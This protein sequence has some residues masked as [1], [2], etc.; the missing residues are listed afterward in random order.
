MTKQGME[1]RKRWGRVPILAVAAVAVGATLGLSSPPALAGRVS[2]KPSVRAPRE[3][4]RL[5][6]RPALLKLYM[7]T[8]KFA[9]A[10]LNGRHVGDDFL[11]GRP[12]KGDG[13][14]R[15]VR[16]TRGRTC[17][18]RASPSHGLRYGA[19]VL[20]ARFKR[21]KSVS[22]RKIRF[23][24][25]RNRPL[26]AAGR[27]GKYGDPGQRIHLNGRRSLIPP[28]VRHRLADS[29]T[30]A[31][32]RYRWQLMSAPHGSDAKLTG[33]HTARPSLK[34]GKIGRYKVRLTVTAPGGRT[35]SDSVL[36][37]SE[38]QG[39][40][41]GVQTDRAPAVWI[42]TMAFAPGSDQSAIKVGDQYYTS[43][44]DSWA[45]LVV[46]D[47]QTLKP[48]EGDLANQ[49]Y[50]C[51][52]AEDLGCED[53]AEAELK[54]DLASLPSTDLAIVANPYN[55]SQSDDPFQLAHNLE[56]SLT[57]IGVAPT[58]F[59]DDYFQSSLGA[60]SAIGV[61]GTT[62][63]KGDWHSVVSRDQGAGEMHGYLIRGSDGDYTFQAP[64]RVDFDTQ[65]KGSSPSQNVIQVGD[66]SFTQSFNGGIRDGGGFQVVV[67]NAQTLQP[68]SSEP[69]GGY[70]FE[71][72][73]SDRQALI[74]QVTAMQDLLHQ[75]NAATGLDRKLVFIAS[76]GSPAIQYYRRSGQ[77]PDDVLNTD[78]SQLVDEVEQLG[79]T[80][81]SFY[82]M[83]DPG[84]YGDNG[85]SYSLL[86]LSNSGGGQGVQAIQPGVSGNGTGPLNVAP[87]SG[88]L[89]R[90]GPNY[91][92]ELQG[93]PRFGPEQ[94]PDPSRGA[95]ELIRVALQPPSLW[96][97]QDPTVFPDAAERARKQA[98]VCW[99]GMDVLGTD[100]LR[101]QYY[102]EGYVNGQFNSSFWNQTAARVQ[103]LDY[104]DYTDWLTQQ[105]NGSLCRPSFTTA[106]LEWAKT[107]LAGPT[108]RSFTVGGEIGW[109]ES[110]HAYLDKLATPFVDKVFESWAELQDLK[111]TVKHDTG[112]SNDEEVRASVGALFN[113]FRGLTEIV[114]G[115][116]EGA[117]A[118]NDIYDFAT[119]I[120]E[121][122]GKPADDDFSTT[123]GKVGKELVDRMDQGQK[124][125]RQQLPNV[126]SAD[127]Q[128]LKTVGSCAS[129]FRSDWAGCPRP[130]D[131]SDWQFGQTA[132]DNAAAT[133]AKSN[134][135]WAYGE[136]LS[137]R[138][139]L[140]K[141]PPWWRTTVGDN[142]DFNANAFPATVFPFE[143]LP[144]TAQLARPIYRNIP[145]YT[146]TCPSPDGIHV[147]RQSVGETWQIS[148]LG[149]L[150][151]GG[152]TLASPYTMGYP[153]ASVTDAI[154]NS[155]ADKGYGQDPESFF[156]QYFPKTVP[157]ENFPYQ[158]ITPRWCQW[159]DGSCH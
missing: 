15:D 14:P 33:A 126:I 68:D 65:A 79:G 96:P 75:A 134:T 43:E 103:N 111:S 66:K 104:S 114:P 16:S 17:R 128:K 81:T 152:G 77:G 9:G 38:T 71:T 129:E 49:S 11:L 92:F 153:N 45:Q 74:N 18:L 116:G 51:P 87:V 102:T 89:G 85:Y 7:G 141:L 142:R 30:R 125:L 78:L 34:L 64:D 53:Y 84:L 94:A 70:W 42:D 67:L 150:Q 46:L 73:H 112:A 20:R 26:A 151:S 98:A 76:L 149:F 156:A 21:H 118:V 59:N 139:N 95:S 147:C 130:F 108:T 105:G 4:Q 8:A 36:V 86:S 2:P 52:T 148:A 117:I 133:L 138:Y 27:D 157:L 155:P 60:I 90:T 101:G 88:T 6:A 106:D 109:L 159:S 57:R 132:Q 47:R 158:D 146:H 127:Y 19:N 3:G 91:D 37:Q 32:L 13:C 145:T 99:I 115:I 69:P 39:V 110:T 29:G 40:P 122:D 154:F 54:H 121:L 12:A 62:P 61:P 23:R 31:R 113:F 1:R 137:A 136:L 93:A 144:G 83:L 135:V 119:D 100:D 131:H 44:N 140:Y 123:V 124:V 55:R 35:G 28:P 5:P 143:G 107:E 50:Q 63:G 24:V 80:R 10:R 97:E 58:G 56:E 25:A 48:I 22:V 72:D 82:K 120:S 41:G